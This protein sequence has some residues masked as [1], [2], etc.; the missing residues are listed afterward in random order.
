MEQGRQPG[1]VVR[2]GFPSSCESLSA[3]LAA[4]NLSKHLDALKEA[5]INDP[6][7]LV[8]LSD[9]LLKAAAIEPTG[10]RRRLLLAAKKL[11]EDSADATTS[12]ATFGSPGGPQ[13]G[14][15]DADSSSCSSYEEE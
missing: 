8:H 6:S 14:S 10:H 12:S 15:R 2:G 4:L 9:D 11:V 1:P 5:G 7:D 3:W 13:I